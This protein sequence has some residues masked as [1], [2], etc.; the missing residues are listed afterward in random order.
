MW[1]GESC[2]AKGVSNLSLETVEF[3]ISYI[4]KSEKSQEKQKGARNY[5][6]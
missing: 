3:G 5:E 1:T 2:P 4:H 6:S